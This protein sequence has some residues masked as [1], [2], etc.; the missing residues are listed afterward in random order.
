MVSEDGIDTIDYVIMQTLEDPKWKSRVHAIM[1]EEQDENPLKGIPSTQTIGRHIDDLAD[2]G[3]IADCILSPD[4]VDR[5]LIIGYKVTEKGRKALEEKR[6]EILQ[7]VAHT[8]DNTACESTREVT[9]SALIKMIAAQFDLD[10]PSRL[11][12]EDEYSEEELLSLLTL[13]YAQEN[14]NTFSTHDRVHTHGTDEE[15]NFQHLV[16]DRD[17]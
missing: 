14:A 11:R 2:H 13:H 1:E 8:T 17:Q 5:E 12:L 7:E 3:Y 15:H 10:D 16:R 6:N 9:K 4:D